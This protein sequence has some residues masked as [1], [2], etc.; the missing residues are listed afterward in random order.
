MSTEHFCTLFDSKFLPAGLC[1]HESLLSLG[2]PFHLW[3]LCMD[4]SVER[5]LS[6]LQLAHV[7][8][9]PL[10]SIESNALLAVKPGRSRAEY[11]W[12][13]TPF[14]PSFVMG[15][16]DRIGRITYLDADLYFFSSPSRLL[17]ELETSRAYVL[18]TEHAYAPQYDQTESAGRFCVQFVT[19]RRSAE[20][21][22]VLQWWQD[23]CIE[24]CFARHEDGKFGDQKYLDQWPS[25]FGNKVHV[26]EGRSLA[27]APWNAEFFLEQEPARFLPVFYH[28]HGLRMIS[29]NSVR[30]FT[31]YQVG[32]KAMAIYKVYVGALGRAKGRLPEMPFF[33]ENLGWRE[34]ARAWLRA[35][36]GRTRIARIPPG[37]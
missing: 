8:L 33:P 12:T 24:W 4:E 10:S 29:P 16:D 28:F 15:R 14:L 9:I 7:S 34:R 30:L 35:L 20:A 17:R 23:R 13:L 26:L 36:R 32:G 37:V 25:L 31:G 18:I 1:L 2:E 22:S 21:Q 11:C 19:F 3:I 27:L 5:Q 6:A